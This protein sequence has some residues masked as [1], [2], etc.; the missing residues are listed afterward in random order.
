M[1]GAPSLLVHRSCWSPACR[2]SVVK[3]A[4]ALFFRTF[5]PGAVEARGRRVPGQRG[6]VGL[7]VQVR[8]GMSRRRMSRSCAAPHRSMDETRCKPYPPGTVPACCGG[9]AVPSPPALPLKKNMAFARS[10]FHK[11]REAEKSSRQKYWKS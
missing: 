1:R 10:D 5:L 3:R 11:Y 9:A 2:V 4:S 8:R 7:E 6:R